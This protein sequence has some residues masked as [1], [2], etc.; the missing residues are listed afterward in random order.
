MYSVRN[1]VG[2]R[3]ALFVLAIGYLALGEGREAAALFDAFWSEP[4]LSKAAWAIVVLVPIVL[5]PAAL[6]LGE[7]LVRQRQAAQAVELRL[8]GVRQDVNALAKPQADTEAAV[9]HLVRTDPEDAIVSMQ[10]RLTEAER[11]AQIQQSR[12][13]TGDLAAR[14]EQLRAQQQALQ[15]RLAPVLEKRRS[16]EQL[17]ME[18]GGRQTD[19]ER[20]LAEVAGGDDAVALDIGLKTMTDFVSQSHARCDA[21]ER[22]SKVIV[23]LNEDFAELQA[24][25]VPFAAV[26][27]GIVR[28][29]EELSAMRDRLGEGIGALERTSQGPLADRVQEFANQGQQLDDRLSQLNAQFAKLA[30]LRTDITA[31]FASFN[32]AL[33][34]L[35][36]ETADEGVGA[37]GF[38]PAREASPATAGPATAQDIDGRVAE[39]AAFIEATQFHLDEIERKAV[40]FAQMKTKLGDLQSR[41]LPLKAAD[42]G[43][44]KLI[45]ELKGI[46]HRLIARIRQI[47]EDDDGDLA[48]RVQRFTETKRE[49][50]KRVASLTEQFAKLATIRKDI[51]GLFEKLSSAVSASSN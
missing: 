4:P 27:D 32:R 30:R 3:G 22:A 19:I 43:V 14:V 46:R 41:L 18:L 6:W 38:T 50:E 13:E 10:Q 48:A 47:E 40:A 23:G 33:D 8:G 26:E 44:A 39:L 21:I 42:G 12:N 15:Q 11:F 31:L 37:I 20:A 35:S 1:V 49:L 25:L 36:V 34:V 24:R 16:I 7:V 5:V 51:A 29:V 45:S 17:F 28:R 9:H 2:I